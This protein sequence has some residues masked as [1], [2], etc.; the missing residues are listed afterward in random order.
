ML[1]YL[2]HGSTSF[3]RRFS[4]EFEESLHRPQEDG[5]VSSNSSFHYVGS[6]AHPPY[7]HI[8]MPHVEKPAF[9][10]A[11]AVQSIL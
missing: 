2:R 9:A 6:Y 4:E 5:F 7:L 10:C 11:A 3:E 8:S 1:S